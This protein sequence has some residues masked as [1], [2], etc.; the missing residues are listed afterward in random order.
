MSTHSQL[1]N[2]FRLLSGLCIVGALIGLSAA[3]LW[4]GPA[5]ASSSIVLLTSTRTSTLPGPRLTPTRTLVTSSLKK[6]LLTG[7]KGGG[8]DTY[9]CS[10]DML[11]RQGQ[12]PSL[13][14]AGRV[15][16]SGRSFPMPLDYVALCIFGLPYDQGFTIELFRP[17]GRPAGIGEYYPGQEDEFYSAPMGDFVSGWSLRPV[18]PSRGGGDALGIQID[19]T[20]AINVKLWAPAGLPGGAWYARVSTP[21]GSTEGPFNV[22]LWQPAPMVML[23]RPPA[24]KF[25]DANPLGAARW[26]YLNF[27][28]T[29]DHP[30][31]IGDTFRLFGA[32]FRPGASVPIGIYRMD[33]MASVANLV[34]QLQ[35]KAN[36]QGD[37]N[38]AF[39]VQGGNPPGL[40][41]LVVPLDLRTGDLDS[42]G[43]NIRYRLEQW[44]PCANTYVSYLAAGMG[45]KVNEQYPANQRVRSA[46]NRN[47]AIVGTMP[48]GEQFQI[49]EGPACAN[50]WVWWRVRSN[51][52]LTGWTAEGDGTERWLIPLE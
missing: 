21:Y 24:Y 52:G 31:A 26:S 17:D 7:G 43:P 23:D 27:S 10:P 46:P 44:R 37:W 40:Y 15:N 8:G 47:A 1:K 35:V 29:I 42:A 48:S 4:K 14:S 2:I 16:E 34:N 9:Y 41:A 12:A 22:P 18:D 3:P 6:Q 45:G 49:L 51:S 33:E 25:P 38:A 11:R 13:V 30:L 28:T 50:N 20:P 5:Q 39:S 36:G 32:G 19:Q